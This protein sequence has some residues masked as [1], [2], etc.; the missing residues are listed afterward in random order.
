MSEDISESGS[1]TFASAFLLLCAR[2]HAQ[3]NENRVPWV[4]N[5]SFFYLKLHSVVPLVSVM[6][7]GSLRS[8]PL[9]S[10]DF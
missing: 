3:R 2:L 9:P 6:A 8:Q 10:R 4:V 5:V 1:I 7:S